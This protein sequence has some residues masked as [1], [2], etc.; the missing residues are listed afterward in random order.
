MVVEVIDEV[1]FG[2]SFQRAR[3]A[4]QLICYYIWACTLQQPSRT[5]YYSMF[6]FFCLILQ[7]SC[8]RIID[9]CHPVRALQPHSVAWK[10]SVCLI[11]VRGPSDVAPAHSAWTSSWRPGRRFRVAGEGRGDFRLPLVGDEDEHTSAL[12]GT[13]SNTR[14]RSPARRRTARPPTRRT[15]A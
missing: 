1:E 9:A 3:F 12:S 14:G 11:R 2:P 4:G 13:R 7:V 10:T 5:C 8:T 6:F 15:G